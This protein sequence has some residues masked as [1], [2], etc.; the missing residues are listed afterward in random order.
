MVGY[1][2]NKKVLI[3]RPGLAGRKLCKALES[4]GVK[5]V[6]FPTLLIKSVDINFDVSSD[7]LKKANLVIFISDSAVHYAHDACLLHDLGHAKIAVIGEATAASLKK[8][9]IKIDV[10][11]D[12]FNSEGLLLHV[13][14]QNVGNKKI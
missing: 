12:E 11:P 3:T 1:M 10:C 9:G 4:I 5:A 13:F 8:V 6:Y 7:L 2:K 14:L